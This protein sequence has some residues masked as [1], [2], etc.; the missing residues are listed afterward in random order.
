MEQLP[1][2]D[3]TSLVFTLCSSPAECCFRPHLQTLVDV[4]RRSE[5]TQR[6]PA[7][8]QLCFQVPSCR[9]SKLEDVL[10]ALGDWC[11]LGFFRFGQ[12]GVGSGL[13]FLTFGGLFAICGVGNDLVDKGLELQKTTLDGT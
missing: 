6:H 13:S 11:A 7:R 1:S 5:T 9:R 8:G 12:E 10:H 3:A 2:D 4:Q